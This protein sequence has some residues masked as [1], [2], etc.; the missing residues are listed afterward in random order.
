MLVR[1]P[2]ARGIWRLRN[3]SAM[4]LTRRA[5][6]LPNNKLP[7]YIV[8]S[9]TRRHH[10]YFLSRGKSHSREGRAPS[11]VPTEGNLI[12]DRDHLIVDVDT[13]DFTGAADVRGIRHRSDRSSCATRVIA[14][15]ITDLGGRATATRIDV[16]DQAAIEAHADRVVEQAGW[17]PPSTRWASAQCRTCRSDRVEGALPGCPREP[18]TLTHKDSDAPAHLSAVAVSMKC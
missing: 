4:P 15:K 12:G 18:I 7:L 17:T 16:F 9:R 2:T 13:T 1:G 8:Q 10:L 11:G 3:P 14:M 6:L 5:S